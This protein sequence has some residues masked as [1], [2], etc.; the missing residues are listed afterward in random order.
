VVGLGEGISTARDVKYLE[1]LPGIPGISKI[2]QKLS[3]LLEY[4]F[5]CADLTS[6]IELKERKNLEFQVLYISVYSDE[7]RAF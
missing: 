2:Y 4:G 1:F 7:P 6:R 5:K 3:K